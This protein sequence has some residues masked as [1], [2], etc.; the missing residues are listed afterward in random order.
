MKKK[1]I[2]LFLM[3]FI[4]TRLLAVEYL[5]LS[6]SDGIVINIKLADNPKITI[7]SNTLFV[8]TAKQEIKVPIE[9]LKEYKLSNTPTAIKTPTTTEA[10][11]QILGIYSIDG[12]KVS[13]GTSSTIDLSSQPKGIYIIKLKQKKYKFINK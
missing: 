4:S 2:L 3:L 13:A 12:K 6:Q 1:K 10:G 11:Y 9:T 7:R 5:V 8:T